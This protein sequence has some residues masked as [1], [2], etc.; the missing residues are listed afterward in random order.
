MMPTLNLLEPHNLM[1]IQVRETQDHHNL[2]M[3]EAVAAA[4]VAAAMVAGALK[5]GAK[6]EGDTEAAPAGRWMAGGWPEAGW[7]QPAAALT[8]LAGPSATTSCECEQLVPR[9]LRLAAETGDVS[10]ALRGATAGLPLRCAGRVAGAG[11]ACGCTCAWLGSGSG[12]GS[13]SG[14]GLGSGQG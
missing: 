10:A 5:V 8:R 7:L 13:E 12:L 6:V 3:E 4:V 2:Q 9:L 1:V 14:L 11:E